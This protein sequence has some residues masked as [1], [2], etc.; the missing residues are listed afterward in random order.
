MTR[1]FFQYRA[2]R[3]SR[4]SERKSPRGRDSVGI[5]VCSAGL[6]RGKCEVRSFH[7]ARYRSRDE[8]ACMLS[9]IIHSYR[10]ARSG[11][12]AVSHTCPVD[13]F[14]FKNINFRF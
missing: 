7:S 8:T 10:G 6:L 2:T 5:R 13:H 4:D 3:D 9:Y 14:T 11:N 12:K 1:A